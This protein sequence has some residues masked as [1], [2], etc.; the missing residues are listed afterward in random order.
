MSST[1]LKNTP[2]EYKLQQRTID[3]SKNYLNFYNKLHHNNSKFPTFGINMGNMPADVL[4]GNFADVDS[5]LK[6]TYFNNLE[7]PKKNISVQINNMQC[8]TF[9][10]RPDILMPDNIY[11]DKNRPTIFRR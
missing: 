10:E 8:A 7:D 11:I 3:H 5:F 4:S 9:F 2:C 6:G 1:R